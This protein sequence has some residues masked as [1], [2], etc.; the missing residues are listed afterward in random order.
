[1]SDNFLEHDKIVVPAGSVASKYSPAAYLQDLWTNALIIKHKEPSN[2][3]SS[4]RKD[5]GELKLNKDTLYGEASTLSFSNNMLSSLCKS[6]KN[7]EKNND[8]MADVAS[9]DYTKYYHH[10]L[11]ILREFV[12]GL[13]DDPFAMLNSDVANHVYA[14]ISPTAPPL[15]SNELAIKAQIWALTTLHGVV[16]EDAQVMCGNNIS[17]VPV[18]DEATGKLTPSQVNRLFSVTNDA[19]PVFTDDTN[20]S[21]ILMQAFG[22]N[23]TELDVLTRLT[24][25]SPD[26]GTDLGKA[27]KIYAW[28]LLSRSL[29]CTIA[30]LAIINQL[31]TGSAPQPW[32]RYT[33]FKRILDW[34]DER[35]I[36]VDGLLLLIN[37]YSYDSSPA[38]NTLKQE[39]LREKPESGVFSATA[40]AAAISSS[41]NISS[42]KLVESA[43]SWLDADIKKG[44]NFSQKREELFSPQKIVSARF[45]LIILPANNDSTINEVQVFVDGNNIALHKNVTS[46]NLSGLGNIGSAV[47]GDMTTTASIASI[48]VEQ[49]GAQAQAWLQIDLGS[50]Y[51]IDQIKIL[52]NT[53]P[54]SSDEMYLYASTV[55]MSA[56]AAHLS[57]GSSTKDLHFLAFSERNGLIYPPRTDYINNLLQRIS[58][59]NSLGLTSDMLAMLSSA[60]TDPVVKEG[61]VSFTLDILQKLSQLKSLVDSCGSNAP[62]LL[63]SLTGSTLTVTQLA[64]YLNVAVNLFNADPS[65]STLTV[66]SASLMLNN[67]LFA[68]R[69][70]MSLTNLNELCQLTT[71]SEFSQ[72]ALLAEKIMAELPPVRFN[73]LQQKIEEKLS[74][75]L[76]LYYINVNA[77]FKGYTTDNLS[78]YLL[79][80]LKTSGNSQT[81]WIAWAIA[82]VQLYI[83]RCLNGLEDI[84]DESYKS[85]QFFEDW[86]RYNNRYSMWAGLAELKYEPENYLDPAMRLN[87]TESFKNLQQQLASGSLNEDSAEG[88]FYSYLTDFEEM[89]KVNTVNA[90]HDSLSNDAGS[91][92][93]IG[94]SMNSP[95]KWFWRKVDHVKLSVQHPI[96]AWSGWSE[97]NIPISPISNNSSV[98]IRPVAFNNRLYVAWLEARDNPVPPTPPDTKTEKS[99]CCILKL[100]H[101]Y[102]DGSWSMPVETELELGSDG[103]DSHDTDNLKKRFSS[104]DYSTL[105]MYITVDELVNQIR[106]CV[107]SSEWYVG[108]MG[109][110]TKIIVNSSSLFRDTVFNTHG[111]LFSGGMVA[112]PYYAN[113]DLSHQNIKMVVHFTKVNQSQSG[114]FNFIS[115]TTGVFTYYDVLSGFHSVSCAVDGDGNINNPYYG[116]EGKIDPT[117]ITLPDKINAADCFKVVKNTTSPETWVMQCGDESYSLS[118]NFP[119]Q[120]LQLTEKGIDAVFS[121]TQ[122]RADKNKLKDL[123]D[124]E[125]ALGSYYWELFYH[126]P[127]LISLQLQ[128]AQDYIGAAKWLGYIYEPGAALIWK[129]L[130]LA[131]DD[132]WGEDINISGT[133]DT[134]TNDPDNIAESDPMHYKLATFM[135]LMDMLISRGDTAYRQ[136][137]RDT[138][139]EAQMWYT[140]AL[141]LLG[142]QPELSEITDVALPSLDKLESSDFKPQENE[143]LNGYWLSLRQRL[144]NLRHN[145]SLDG[146]PLNLPLFSTPVNPRD[147][148]SA[149]SGFG[150]DAT[151]QNSSDSAGLLRFQP[152]LVQARSQIG[153]LVQF[154][155]SLQ[156]IVERQDEEA[157]SQLLQTQASQLLQITSDIQDSTL[158]AITADIAALQAQRDGVTQ[159]KAYYTNLY[160]ANI[161]T[162]E[163]TALSLNKAAAALLIAGGASNV[164]GG[165]LDTAAPNIFGVADGGNRWGGVANGI[166]GLLANTG[167]SMSTTAGVL[168]ESEGYRRRREEWQQQMNAADSELK[169]LDNQITALQARQQAGSMQKTYLLTQQ[170]QSG[171]QLQFLKSKYTNLQL[172]N[173]MRS[174]LSS[175][176]WQFYD[177][178]LASCLRVEQAY[179][180]EV[181]DKTQRYI[182]PGAWQD[183]AAGLL[184]G[185]SLLLDLAHMEAAW[186]AWNKRTLEVTRTVSLA[187]VLKGATANTESVPDLTHAIKKL[188]GGGST[189][190]Y[191]WRDKNIK[192]LKHQV[193]MENNILE[194]QIN[195]AALNIP[196]DYPDA[197]FQ[198]QIPVR[199]IKSI[200]VSLPAL[201]GPYQDIQ[202]LLSYDQSGLQLPSGCEAIAVSHGVNDSGLF[203]LDFNDPRYLPFEGVMLV[204]PAKDTL[205]TL[206]LKFPDATGNQKELLSSLNDIILHIHYTIRK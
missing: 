68:K 177:I 174:R 49:G 97:V 156:S 83:D 178:T 10:P 74:I 179:K 33:T 112:Y 67:Y 24:G 76:S 191:S 38:M 116:I 47:D 108:E 58:I 132:Q 150:S 184:C 53:N 126:V 88:A 115:N 120:L 12:A 102:Y 168:T 43:I 22:I 1:M 192:S 45:I 17:N 77:S 2:S 37:G 31:L 127:L 167:F 153:Q 6:A 198:G 134:K 46:S 87:A 187:S 18:I 145:L 138:L 19:L 182:R 117:S 27:S 162:D 15:L 9:K 204:A 70:G 84:V 69:S 3:L 95:K 158:S 65:V 92:W 189:K 130:P 44:N 42:L 5:L 133:L 25:I 106:V 51:E 155:S 80:D 81:S 163:N 75:A 185:E 13:G 59:A 169:Q 152:A 82:S 72:W 26:A 166:G 128:Q 40:L 30:E 32:M 11:V 103:S 21:K 35:K 94:Q 119:A 23:N 141:D 56:N 14:G 135:R 140:Q 20:V 93:F 205:G 197:L 109:V 64:Q 170:R 96:Q 175:I 154:G 139:V 89:T 160:N 101:Q 73:A 143:K 199:R 144:F 111:P 104:G 125:G 118:S 79:T 137:E 39:Y 48:P 36:T 114:F 188:L 131:N 142:P 63:S 181:G 7:F 57:L 60:S 186:L 147:I 122:L 195:L 86:E 98:F 107:G 172:Y 113:E 123:L 173:W 202:A 29:G 171:Q 149:E 66:S 41:F 159:R 194:C 61:N 91:T 34:L 121:L 183:S 180:F 124:F 62:A 52:L 200:S 136:L 196:A 85:V 157:M 50:L 78:S 203:Q 190:N 165:A 193:S 129:P 16:N 90:Y 148:L 146:Q 71:K 105:S 99:K 151:D 201:V 176:F 8:L 55:D 54:G 161:S 110:V 4:R 100:A 206:S 28:V 164:I